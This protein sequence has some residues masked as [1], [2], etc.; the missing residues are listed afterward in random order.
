MS[1]FRKTLEFFHPLRCHGLTFSSD[2]NPDA[3]LTFLTQT[4]TVPAALENHVNIYAISRYLTKQ[5]SVILEEELVYVNHKM[6]LM[7]VPFVRTVLKPLRTNI[8]IS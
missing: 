3:R 7:R 6:F 2:R 8:T 4:H 1:K 5:Y